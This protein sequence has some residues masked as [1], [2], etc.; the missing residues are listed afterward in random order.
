YEDWFEPM[1]D[2]VSEG[3]AGGAAAGFG[4]ATVEEDWEDAV[5]SGVSSGITSG[6]QDALTVADVFDEIA[7]AGKRAEQRAVAFGRTT[8][9]EVDSL[10]TRL[11]VLRSGVDKLLDLDLD[12]NSAEVQY[13]VNRVSELQEELEKLG[14]TAEETAE[15]LE[16]VII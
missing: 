13:L 3:I 8:A 16:P 15:K 4:A 6:I 10:N 14:V 2:A 11:G 7:A 5:S 1:F 9:A 12:P